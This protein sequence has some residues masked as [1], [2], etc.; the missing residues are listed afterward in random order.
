MCKSAA[1]HGCLLWRKGSHENMTFSRT[2]PFTEGMKLPGQPVG[3]WWIR[4]TVVF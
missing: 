1:L 3:R 2:D 4:F